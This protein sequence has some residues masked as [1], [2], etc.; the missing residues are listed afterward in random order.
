MSGEELSADDIYVLRLIYS[1]YRRDGSFAFHSAASLQPRLTFLH[2]DVDPAI[3]L[4][5]LAAA[6]LL[7]SHDGGAYMLSPEGLVAASHL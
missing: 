3:A 5:K 2:V 7:N 6:G 1:Q 4:Q